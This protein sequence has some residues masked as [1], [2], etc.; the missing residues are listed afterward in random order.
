MQATQQLHNTGQRLWLDNI[1]RGLI[2]G[3]TLQRY[4]DELSVT[5]LTSNPSIFDQA[6][7]Q[8]DFYDAAIR[9]KVLA[10][11]SGEALFFNLALEDLTAAADLFQPMFAASDGADGWV[12]LE[13]SP[14][15]ADD[16]KATVDAAIQLYARAQR[17]NLFIKIPGTPA[18]LA[19][20]DQEP[21]LRALIREYFFVSL[22]RACAE[23]LASENASR[24]AAM[25]RAEKNIDE[26]Q[27]EL[28]RTFH[29]LRQSSID[30]ELFDV[31]SGFEIL[32]SQ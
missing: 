18:G 7:R 2:T 25:Q 10:G 14:L 27:E 28:N 3:G 17:S 5:G 30:E 4:I 16:S 19:A 13:V 24:L 12:S 32:A 9:K 20:N 8:T 21:T 15:L 6:I 26:L 23:S 22:F 29:R 1:T 11:E 31:F